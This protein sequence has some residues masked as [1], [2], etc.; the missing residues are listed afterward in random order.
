MLEKFKML[1]I[2]QMMA[3]IKL[4][5]AWKASRDENY[6]IQMKREGTSPDEAQ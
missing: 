5:E 2:N 1:S 6:L 3:Q 4:T